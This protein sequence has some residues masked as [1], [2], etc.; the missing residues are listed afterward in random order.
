MARIA[1]TQTNPRKKK[2][3]KNHKKNKKILLTSNN[4]KGMKH[5]IYSGGSDINPATEKTRT[6]SRK[7]KSL[8]KQPKPRIVKTYDYQD[9][10]RQ[11]LYQIVRYEP[12][13]EGE[14]KSFRVRRPNPKNPPDLER[15]LDPNDPDDRKHWLR[16]IG[17]ETRRVLYRLPELLDPRVIASGKPVFVPEGEKDVER[18][19]NMDLPAT[20][21]ALGADKWLPEYSDFLNDRDVVILPDNDERGKRHADKVAKSLWLVNPPS[22]KILELP[23]LD[24][25]GDVSD[26]LDKGGTIQR[27]LALAKDTLTFIPDSE[28]TTATTQFW[29]TDNYNA[30]RL[31]EQ[32]G[33]IIRYCWKIGWIVYDG[34]RWNKDEGL[35]MA[36]SLATKTAES[37][38]DECKKAKRPEQKQ[39]VFKHFLKSQNARKIKDMLYMAQSKDKTKTHPKQLD[40]DIYLFNCETGTIN[41]KTG[42]HREH[43]PDDIITKLAPVKYDPTVKSPLWSNCLNTW[44][45]NDQEKIA[46]LQKLMGMCLTG[47]ICARVFPI[48][49]GSGANGKSVFLDTI[50]ELMGDY[51][52]TAPEDLL[53]EKQYHVHPTEIAVLNGRRLVTLD[54]TKPNMRLRTAL[55][56]RMT[57]DRTLQGRFMRENFFEFHTTHKT[58][59]ITQNLPRITETAD[60]IWD[61]L[62]LLPW[63]VRI[64]VQ[65]QNPYL[66][67]RLKSEWPGILNWLIEGCLAWQKE[68]SKLTP[69]EVVK[70]STENYR[71]ESDPL[72]DFVEEILLLNMPAESKIRKSELRTAYDQW[73]KQNNVKF[74]ISNRQLSEY[75]RIRGIRDGQAKINLKVCKVWFGIGLQEQLPI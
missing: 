8:Q 11:L 59:L 38:L 67:D 54:E 17:D 53:I 31:V 26:W 30:N 32:Y 70:T 9:E 3:D 33:D 10:K 65:E 47:D 75:F 45:E 60:A 56:K 21:C 12:G 72:A 69:P 6:K 18:L 57:G 13:F 64:P 71:R 66:L 41:L 20:T 39:E 27:L 1:K 40:S 48:F 15:R 25:K 36:Q 51:A 62:H 37:L 52:L 4:K 29:P 2:T 58:I 34:K 46:Y 73:A 44:M 50:R 24:E 74:P 7:T 19:L 22:I 35:A 68:G 5:N 16:G 63:S 49:H 43:R 42:E 55:V 23:G 14:K 28:T 61:R